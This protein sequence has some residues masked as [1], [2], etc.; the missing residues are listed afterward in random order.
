MLTQVMQQELTLLTKQQV[1]FKDDQN[2]DVS[3]MQKTLSKQQ[4]DNRNQQ[5]SSIPLIYRQ[6]QSAK[7]IRKEGNLVNLLTTQE[8][9]YENCM[10]KKEEKKSPYSPG[11]SDDEP[12]QKIQRDEVSEKNDE[13]SQKTD[14][15]LRDQLNKSIQL[16]EISQRKDIQGQLEEKEEEKNDIQSQDSIQNMYF[17][18]QNSE[19]EKIGFKSQSQKIYEFII[20]INLSDYLAQSQLTLSELNQIYNDFLNVKLND[21]KATSCKLMIILIELY[22]KS[23]RVKKVICRHGVSEFVMAGYNIK[24]KAEVAIFVQLPQF[25]AQKGNCFEKFKQ[26]Q[27]QVLQKI[28]S[29]QFK[30]DQINHNYYILKVFQQFLIE[31]VLGLV[32]ITEIFECDLESEIKLQQKDFTNQ[33]L[34]NIFFQL[35]NALTEIHSNDITH[36]Q[37]NPRNILKMQNGQYKLSNFG[38][39]SLISSNQKI[40]QEEIK[41][42]SPEQMEC[43]KNQTSVLKMQDKS[44]VYSMGLTLMTLFNLPQD[45]FS[46]SDIREGKFLEQKIDDPVQLS[47]MMFIKYYMTCKDP[48]NRFN[49]L[50]LRAILLSEFSKQQ[51]NREQEY[52]RIVKLI[53]SYKAQNL[54]THKYLSYLYFLTAQLNKNPGNNLIQSIKIAQLNTNFNNS[55]FLQIQSMYALILSSEHRF[56]ESDKILTNCLSQRKQLYKDQLHYDISDAINSFAISYT[57]QEEYKLALEQDLKTLELRESLYGME[58]PEII[59]SY[60]NIASTYEKLVQ[61]KKALEYKLKALNMREQI[62]TGNHPDL[63][64]IFNSLAQTYEVLGDNKTAQQYDFKA[65]KMREALQNDEPSKL[66]QSYCRIA[67]SYERLG[68]DKTSLEYKLKALKI[69]ETLFQGNHHD[70]AFS[71]NSVA[72][73][74]ER[75]GNYKEAQDYFLRAL[76]MREALY[77][78]KHPD[79][80]ESYNSIAAFYSRQGDYSKALDYELKSLYIREILY[81]KNHPDIAESLNNVAVAYEKLGFDEVAQ[82]YDLQAMKMREALYNQDHPELAQSYS[83]MGVCYER[84]RNYQKALEYE[85]KALKMRSRLYEGDHPDVA[86]S[87]NNLGICYERIGSD[88]KALELKIKSLQMR[89]RIYKQEHA[90]VAESL[91]SVAI[92]YGRIGENQKALEHKL[93]AL[94]I[95]KKIYQDNHPEIAE[96]LSSIAVTYEKLGDEEKAYEYDQKALEMRIKVYQTEQHPEVADSYQNL[97]IYYSRKGDHQTSLAYKLKSLTIRKSLYNDEKNSD[98]AKQL[99]SVAVTYQKLGNRKFALDFFLKALKVREDLFSG[100]HPDLVESYSNL[101]NFFQ[102]EGDSIKQQEYEQ[103]LKLLNINLLSQITQELNLCL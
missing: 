86:E 16:Q 93:K 85:K 68:D 34:I 63:I 103:K 64:E 22:S 79:L 98:I 53:S 40:S 43:I 59:R 19:I 25:N 24:T 36:L 15:W 76:K 39:F 95:R 6:Y 1:S 32:Q 5:K 56:K 50:K 3:K 60:L 72:I 14:N 23:Y 26:E 92:S 48:N 33:N 87:Y 30:L 71:L 42:Y 11:S 89:E 77:H 61:H 45:K 35:I 18:T 4:N 28:I 96:S 67:V 70:L 88:K 101:A 47:L 90:D 54:H 29:E 81:L 10:L 49:S 74:Y 41:F 100:N 62:N 69:R 58:H 66:A 78:G 2:Q 27:E 17:K 94:E 97:A 9:D 31:P 37:L 12:P 102:E 65:V 91:N 44:D 52:L 99:N 46:I 80:A 75:L 8:D 13:Y 51:I 7:D 55:D 84:Q 83:N 21:D 57:T 20:E 38:R 73:S 82:E